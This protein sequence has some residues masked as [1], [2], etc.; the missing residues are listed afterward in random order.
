MDGGVVQVG[1]AVAGALPPL[2]LALVVH[3]GLEVEV[4]A[5]LAVFEALLRLEVA[6]AEVVAL[7]GLEDCGSRKGA[8][9]S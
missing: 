8:K 2:A 6:V 7:A 4:D 3:V 5:V 9:V 1:E